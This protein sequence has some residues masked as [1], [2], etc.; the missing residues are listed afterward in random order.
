MN[1]ITKRTRNN[2]FDIVKIEK[3]YWAGEID[4]V[5][6]L[7]KMFDLKSLPSTDHRFHDMAGDI[8][9]HRINNPQD[10][11][12]DWIFYDSRLDLLNVEDSL[13]LEFLCQML[14]PVVRPDSE[15]SYH[16]QKLFNE[17]LNDDGFEIIEKNKLAGRPIFEPKPKNIS[18]IG[19]KK[20]DICFHINEEYVN[21]Q[22]LL[23]ESSIESA[24][25]LAIGTA[26]ELIETICN[27]ILSERGREVNKDWE[28]PRLLKETSKVL[29][30]TPEDIPDDAKA[31]AT[32]KNI[33]GSLSAIVHGI[34]ELRNSYG[35]GHG[36]HAKFKG[37]A[38]RHAKLAVGAAS[39]L[40]AFLL[41]TNKIK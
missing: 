7:E 28:V 34:A 13:F 33:L 40:A 19:S 36:R 8:W 29:K 24:P 11:A 30:L 14:H 38:P 41:E 16:L 31:S 12:N 26:K 18:S 22:I 32:I 10:W 9:Q 27:T 3:V 4:D 21:N 2:I 39:T 20:E 15:E 1:K 25:Y 35:S 6:F 5:E 37:L 17:C 23:M